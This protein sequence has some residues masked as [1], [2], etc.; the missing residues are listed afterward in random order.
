MDAVFVGSVRFRF[1]LVV[2]DVGCVADD[3]FFADGCG[4]G[5]R[6]L[7]GI[8]IEGPRVLIPC[9][10]GLP[11]MGDHKIPRGEPGRKRVGY[12]HASHRV[13]IAVQSDRPAG[14]FVVVVGLAGIVRFQQDL[15]ADALG[16]FVLVAES[17]DDAVPDGKSR[18]YAVLGGRL[19]DDLVGTRQSIVEL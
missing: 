6:Q 17:I 12:V 1:G 10:P 16:C 14:R 5:N 13:L 2:V 9:R 7:A 15:L 11:V 18:F 8:R 19:V 4:E 3:D